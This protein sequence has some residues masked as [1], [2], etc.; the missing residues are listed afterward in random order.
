MTRKAKK[1]EIDTTKKCFYL[2]FIIL[3]P[4]SP[5]Y[6]GLLGFLNNLENYVV[7]EK[8]SNS[9]SGGHLNNGY[10]NVND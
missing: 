2:R 5:A 9:F 1:E 4:N 8:N 7:V 10:Q 6:A 3:K